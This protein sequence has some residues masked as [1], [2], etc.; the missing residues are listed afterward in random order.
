MGP[1]EF[2]DLDDRIVDLCVG[3]ESTEAMCLRCAVRDTWD[4]EPRGTAGWHCIG[5]VA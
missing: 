5:G 2:A 4:D 3:C 1:M